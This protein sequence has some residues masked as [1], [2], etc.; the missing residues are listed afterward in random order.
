ML[1]AGR[2]IEGAIHHVREYIRCGN[3]DGDGERRLSVLKNFAECIEDGTGTCT[4]VNFR[5][6]HIGHHVPRR[7]L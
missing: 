3:P 1:V 7:E 4:S 6:A 2:D 5:T